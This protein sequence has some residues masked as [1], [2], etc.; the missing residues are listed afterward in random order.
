M[1]R[2]NHTALFRIFRDREENVLE[3][4]DRG[5]R[6]L[7]DLVD[8][9]VPADLVVAIGDRHDTLGRALH[10]SGPTFSGSV[11]NGESHLFRARGPSNDAVLLAQCIISSGLKHRPGF[12]PSKCHELNRVSSPRRDSDSSC[13]VDPG[14]L[15][16]R[17]FYP[18]ADVICLFCAEFGGL[19]ETMR[20][21]AGWLD[22]GAPATLFVRPWLIVVTE[23]ETDEDAANA[24]GEILER[25]P[26]T[27]VHAYFAGIRT[28]GG[29]TVGSRR[30][31]CVQL[32][33]AVVEKMREL[34]KTRE[35][36]HLLFSARHLVAF[37]ERSAAHVM[38]SP[39]SQLD[40]IKTSRQDNVVPEDLP[41]HL[42]AFLGQIE[43]LTEIYE[44][45][46]PMVASSLLL[47]SYPP[48]M[49]LFRPEDV[50]Q[51]L[52]REAL[53]TVGKTAVLSRGRSSHFVLPSAFVALVQASLEEA[54][55]V[56]R[57]KTATAIQLH[58]QMLTK[59]R[60]RWDSLRS[61][62]TCL[63]CIRR[64]AQF[65]LPCGHWI[66]ENCPRLFGQAGPS[67]PWAYRVDK[68]F[69]CGL[70]TGGMSIRSWPP[71]AGF[72][73]LSI[74]GGGARGRIPL[75]FI[76]VFQEHLPYPVQENFDVVFGTSS[77]AL[78]LLGL[79]INGWCVEDCIKCFER[80]A[81]LAFSSDHFWKLPVICGIWKL[82][83]PL[84][85]DGFYSSRKLEVA[86]KKIFGEH[87]SM[88]DDSKAVELGC[89]IGIPVTS[90]HGS[91]YI[92]TNYNAVGVAQ[93]SDGYELISSA[94]AAPR[95][96]IWEIARS[97]TAA[98]YFYK[99]HHIAGLGTFW[100]GGVW[101]NNPIAIALREAARLFPEAKAP[102]LVVS[103]GTGHGPSRATASPGR[104][105]GS[106]LK[107]GFAVRLFRTM[108]DQ[109]SGSRIWK[110]FMGY[111]KIESN[112]TE[113]FRFDVEFT[114]GEP[115]LDNVRCMDQVS[116]LARTT[117]SHSAE[118]SKS[119]SCMIA[120]LFFFQLDE[121]PRKRNGA[122]SCSGHLFCRLRAGRE[123]F[124]A[125]MRDLDQAN[126][127]IA[128][129]GRCLPGGFQSHLSLAQDGN[130]KKRVTF[131]V[132][133]R[134]QTISMTLYRSPGAHF[135]IGG[136]PFSLDWLIRVQ[137]LDA[138]FGTADHRKR[139]SQDRNT[140][141]RPK[142]G[143]RV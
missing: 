75:E 122:Y 115:R 15:Y 14:Y 53:I 2:C 69:L 143:R 8:V 28:L 107:D 91:P 131:E 76:Q 43:R 31:Q 83:R 106:M 3:I 104:R 92:F 33:N 114:D 39:Q 129:D 30:G 119:I 133:S 94:E 44:F 11:V 47:D 136:S 13:L 86:L 116:L 63:A 20:R 88:L 84:I 48:D 128:A 74:D 125:L 7:S 5:R 35:S 99:P 56:L 40:T 27:N 117:I 102:G 137:R 66:C 132:S 37:L 64:N 127:K 41:G 50:M 38:H 78:V 26:K 10:V 135:N 82:I 70:D 139:K 103:L 17:I 34:R 62:K 23:E 45:A 90:I 123:G 124:V 87:K 138:M 51:T 24:L 36:L 77:G 73:V 110:D 140:H 79:F 120:R 121:L 22:E 113:Y 134:E 71:T 67:D 21:L 32:K 65:R 142:R 108:M 81:H 4:H 95:I 12:T 130:F 111:K 55:V 9:D 118:L 126:T 96:P 52:Y 105:A 100:D 85:T 60:H 1:R 57:A 89:R 19:Q 61:D 141:S 6:I 59:F 25:Q 58:L 49:H 18:W 93:S 98:P 68:C 54:F 80:V 46:A 97:A 16:H 101:L 112:D 72:R 29:P 42:S 109:M